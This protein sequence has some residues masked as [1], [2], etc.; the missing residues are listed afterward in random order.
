M[1]RHRTPPPKRPSRL[2]RLD[3]HLC[4]TCGKRTYHSRRAAK[5]A[6]TALAD[7]ALHVYRACGD[8]GGYHLGHHGNGT[9]EQMRR[10]R[11]AS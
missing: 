5:Q 11:T 8:T 1:T 10:R 6:R 3:Y 9:R 7:P 2:T 4:Q